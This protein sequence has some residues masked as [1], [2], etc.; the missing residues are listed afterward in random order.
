[1]EKAI[2]LL[3]FC[4][5]ISVTNMSVYGE[6]NETKWGVKGGIN[7]SS[8]T[9][10]LSDYEPRDTYKKYDTNYMYNV[11]FNTG[12]FLEF[13][14]TDIFSFQPELL[15][16]TK[17]MRNES[18]IEKDVP[19]HFGLQTR[20]LHSISKIALY[21]IECPLYL[22]VSLDLNRSGKFIAGIGPYFAYGISGKMKSEFVISESLRHWIGEKNIFI[23]DDLEFNETTSDIDLKS[24][25]R[26]P[27]WYKSLKRFDGGISGFIGYELYKKWF[28]TTTYDMGMINFLNSA[29]AWDGKVDGRMYNSTFSISLGYKF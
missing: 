19:T 17:G 16:S 6:K 7:G 18:Y 9:V 22:K 21:Y 24:W 1:M 5:V 28:I 11:G 12:I 20:E 29:E 13:T 15:L 2:R 27:Y 3:A 14:L 23:E 25:I 10:S 26:E 8:T 4:I